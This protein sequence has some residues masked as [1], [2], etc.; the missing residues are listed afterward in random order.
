MKPLLSEHANRIE[1][2]YRRMW[3]PPVADVRWPRG[4]IHELPGHFSVLTFGRVLDNSHVTYATRCISQPDDVPP[5]EVFCQVEWQMDDICELLTA[6]AHFHRTGTALGPNHTVNFGRPFAPN[7]LLT[8]G[9]LSLPYQIP[10]EHAAFPNPEGEHDTRLL[11]LIPITEKEKQF[12]VSAG[13]DAFW[14]RVEQMELGYEN[15]MVQNR[16]CIA[17]TP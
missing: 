17:P 12:I 8:H 4:P 10:P 14:S 7:S 13:K 3:G 11:W 1:A 5:A 9:L 16:E 6:I 15:F 2:H